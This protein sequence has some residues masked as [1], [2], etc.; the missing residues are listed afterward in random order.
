MRISSCLALGFVMLPLTVAPSAQGT[1]AERYW[2]QWRGPSANGISRTATPPLE[3]SEKQNVRWK[4]EIPGRGSS[5]PVIWGDRVFIT[6]AIPAGSNLAD[7]HR[8]LGGV[9]PRT[10]HRFVVMA[11][12]RRDLV[13][14]VK[15]WEDKAI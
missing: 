8:P 3:W 15:S 6:T 2:H 11:L 10:P 4:V 12:D 1:Q 7:S 9:Q 5:S 14:A 13:S